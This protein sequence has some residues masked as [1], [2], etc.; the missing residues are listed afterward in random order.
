MTDALDFL[1]VDGLLTPEDRDIRDTVR[2]FAQTELAPHVAGWFSDGT[3]PDGLGLEL[4]K[5]G[6]LG[7]HLE[8][9]GCA[10]TT[11]TA[12][13]VACRELE[14]VDSGLRSFV[15][16]QGSLAM[17]A[18]HRWGTEE[19]RQEWLPRMA[20]GEALGCFGLTEAD[21][22]SDPASMRTR[23]VRDGDDWVLNGSKMWITNGT[24]AEV[25]VVWAQTDEGIRGFVVPT[26]TPGFTATKIG[27][28]LSLRASITAEL[29]FDDLRLP[30]DAVFPEVRGLKGPL[31]CLNEA[32]YGILWGVVGAA[33]AC[34]AEALSYSLERSTFGKPLASFQLTQRKLADMVVAVNNASLAAVQIGRLKDAGE[35]VPAQVSFGKLANVRAALD[36][37]RSARS[38]LGG[39][40]ITL[41]HTVMRHMNNLETV[42]TY[43][44]T[45]EMHLLSV[46]AE[47]TG[48]RAFR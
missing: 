38:I 16:V 25:A 6:L 1:A 12:Y 30:G 35:L 22:G 2:S 7:M 41:D 29:S 14:A 40:G 48:I 18:I 20:A 17:F 15:S 13:G 37:A 21:A 10:G 31:T 46:G 43:E 11:A 8:G 42:L 23:A 45:E 39:A 24:L 19:H 47:V 28:K 36:V 9:Y 33:R 44:G 34:Y 27:R 32:R 5:L 26:A 3:L 4:G